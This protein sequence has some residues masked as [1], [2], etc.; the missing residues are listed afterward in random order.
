MSRLFRQIAVTKLLNIAVSPRTSRLLSG[1]LIG[2]VFMAICESQV[3]PALGQCPGKT[4]ESAMGT[5]QIFKGHDEYVYTVAISRDG[6]TM[7]TAAGDNRA[8]IW[9]IAQR[10]PLHELAHDSAVYAAAFS[11]DGRLI[12]SASGEGVVAIWNAANGKRVAQQREHKDAVYAIAFSPDGKMLAS[13][14]GSTD[15]GDTTCRIWHVDGLKLAKE[16]SGHKR[17]VYGVAFSPDGQTLAT[18]S[19]DKTIRLWNVKTG[20]FSTLRGHTSDVYRCQFS[21]DGENLASVSQD[22]TLRIWKLKSGRSE[23]VFESARKDPV[24]GVT[25]SDDGFWLGAT[26]DDY[27]VRL[28]RT[29][30]MEMTLEEKVSGKSLYAIA[31]SPDQNQFFVAGEE[32]DVRQYAAPGR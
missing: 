11:P 1:F 12:A 4:V 7:V 29:S 2:A 14:G 13:V 32:G 18:G 25:F 15:G 20:E 5:P 22:G 16:F 8:I 19:S 10:Q 6:K 31:I 26:G 17:Q 9:G 24:Y 27:H 23:T 21:P 3:C 30:D 28:W